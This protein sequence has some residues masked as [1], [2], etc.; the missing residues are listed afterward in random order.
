MKFPLLGLHHFLVRKGSLQGQEKFSKQL[1]K[2]W[3]N[4]KIYYFL[5]KNENFLKIRYILK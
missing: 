3:S 4:E 1:L 2:H 5:K